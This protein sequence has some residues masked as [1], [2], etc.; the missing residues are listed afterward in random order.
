MTNLDKVLEF[1]NGKKATIA[2]IIF[3]IMAYLASIGVIGQNEVALI[4]AIVTALGGSANYATA[5]GMLAGRIGR[6]DR[7]MVR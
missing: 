3:A 1:L 5:E 4:T 7:D 6:S 2:A